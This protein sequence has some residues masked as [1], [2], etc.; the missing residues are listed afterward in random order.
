MIKTFADKEAEKIFGETRSR[1]L[2]CDIRQGALNKL[3]R[4][5]FATAIEDLRAFPGINLFKK[6]ND[7]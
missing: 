1:K 7:E 6:A 3:N 5:R 4:I 2:P